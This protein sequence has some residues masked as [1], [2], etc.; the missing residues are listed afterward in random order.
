MVALMRKTALAAALLAVAL[1]SISR[2]ARAEVL[3]DR[4]VAVVG[5]RVIT[6]SE[7]KQRA[8][9]LQKRVD[10]EK[11]SAGQRAAMFTA[12]NKDLLDRMI[13]EQLEAEAAEKAHIVVTPD[14]IERGLGM[15]AEQNKMSPAELLK[16]AERQGMS[17][18]TYRAELAR[19]IL[20]GKLLQRRFPRQ[21]AASSTEPAL[22]ERER[23]AWL[24]TLREA[25]HVEVRL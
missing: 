6:L 8:W 10:A 17:P 3:V 19:Q 13:D 16:D 12:L 14:E 23:V 15:V 20:E 18:A 5:T 7:L 9:P 25:T 11:P 4:I 2:G 24:R 1:G 21:A 22:I